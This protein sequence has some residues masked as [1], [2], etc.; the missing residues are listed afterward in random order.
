[1][2]S[3]T[4][5][6]CLSDPLICRSSQTLAVIGKTAYIYGGEIRPREPVDSSL[7]SFSIGQDE[8]VQQIPISAITASHAPQP[9]VGTASTVI[10]G[11]MFVFSGRGGTAMAPI[12]EHGA[13]WSFDPA[14]Q[15]WSEITPQDRESPFPPGRSYH[16]LANDGNDTIYLHSGCLAKDR[17]ADLW[18]FDV[19][20]R[21]WRQCA[22]APDPPRGGASITFASGKL[23][24]MNGFDGTKEQGGTLDIFSPGDNSWSTVRFAADGREGPSPRSVCCLLPLKIRGRE[25]LLTMFG[26][27]DPSSLGHQGAGRMLGDVWVFDVDSGHW[28]E[29]LPQGGSKPLPRGW[30]AADV[31]ADVVADSTVL[32]QGGL[33]MSNER[34]DDA[35]LLEVH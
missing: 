21:K 3:G 16:A 27:S 33:S 20:Q 13:F 11:K 14:T 12:E 26:E 24:R 6:R 35:W 22:A 8:S 7:Y 9:R 5:K 25:T 2:L 28:Q 15:S 29:I 17:L 31:V 19:S 32:L 18:A 34:L 4:W 30:F 10:Q 23:W 1:M